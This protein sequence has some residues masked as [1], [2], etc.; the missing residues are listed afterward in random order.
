M[1]SVTDGSMFRHSSWSELAGS[2]LSPF[3]SLRMLD[4]H[5]QV[6]TG[7]L[8]ADTLGDAKRHCHSRNNP[9]GLPAHSHYKI[10]TNKT[11]WQ[12]S[13]RETAPRGALGW[14]HPADLSTSDVEP[15]L[16][17]VCYCVGKADI[18][19]ACRLTDHFQLA[20]LNLS[21]GLK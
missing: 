7:T 4:D 3:S 8:L 1:K 19:K 5:H 14:Q 13:P 12:C 6:T 16:C 9:A 15:A 20:C 17:W 21:H 11:I 10:L 18:G 2:G